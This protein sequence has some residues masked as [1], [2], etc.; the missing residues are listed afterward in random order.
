MAIVE[1][2]RVTI[3]F[4]VDCV[5]AQQELRRTGLPLKAGILS[6]P[7]PAPDLLSRSRQL[8]PLNRR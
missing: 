4:S 1:N 3:S 2:L 8:E 7:P 5:A 6:S